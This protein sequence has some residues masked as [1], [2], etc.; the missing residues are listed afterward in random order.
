M[1]NTKEES[2]LALQI[3]AAVTAKVEPF[4]VEIV[5]ID[6]GQRLMVGVV[7]IKQV[8]GYR[9]FMADG[10]RNQHTPETFADAVVDQVQQHVG[11]AMAAQA[12]RDRKAA[13]RKVSNAPGKPTAANELNEGEND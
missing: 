8:F 12:K 1:E 10:T 5:E 9:R 4:E 7:G 11:R 13:R 6:Y 3:R 2:T